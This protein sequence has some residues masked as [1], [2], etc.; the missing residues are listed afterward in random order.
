MKNM[1]RLIALTIVFVIAF[2]LI[3]CTDK[4]KVTEFSEGGK[5]FNDKITISIMM[6]SHVNAPYNSEWK[7][8]E[9]IQESTGTRLN[10]TAIPADYQ[11]KVAL[12]YIAP[13]TTPD[14]IIGDSKQFADLFAEQKSVIA[15]DDYMDIMPNYTKFWNSIP[16]E[17]REE[18]LMYRKASDGKTYFPQLYGT[19][20]VK[21][22]KTW[23][24]RKDIFDKHNLKTPETTGEL[25]DAAVKLKEIYPNSYPVLIRNFF[26]NGVNTI[27]PEWKP[28]FTWNA[29]YDFKNEKWCYGSQ[30]DTM[31]EIIKY[32][33]KLYD[34]TLIPPNFIT[35][36]AADYNE[37]VYNNRTFMFPQFFVQIELLNN[38][39]RK[40]NP[41]FTIAPMLP[42]RAE[43]GQGTNKLYKHNIDPTGYQICNTGNKD[44]IKKTIRFID[45]FYSDEACELL[46]WGKKGE[47]YE[48]IDGKK[49]FILDE[50]EDVSNKYGFQ[51][52]GIGLR[53]EK[54]AVL[55]YYSEKSQKDL[56]T[57]LGNI[58]DKYNPAQWLGFT[59]DELST[60]ND[61][62]AAV[63]TYAQE[64]INKFLIGNEPLSKWDSYVTNLNEMGIDELLESYKSAYDRVKQ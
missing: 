29:Y 27:G 12:A 55:S 6:P 58:E 35:M 50:F 15:I 9:Y 28:Y 47:T 8:L 13:D 5:P 30:E 16:K 3:S 17:E 38:K 54:E 48:I 18:L 20:D 59:S 63:D 51:T 34:E 31:L 64:M 41:E 44:R 11:T 14:L 42:P 62:G 52:Y 32:F 53:L 37:L 45:W 39:N 4:P 23:M 60:K 25:Y 24:Y 40:T 61:I 26:T 57:V 36:A 1:K 22:L 19:H 21:N 2:T 56:K 43:N 7:A 10:I 46:S 49:K 33:K